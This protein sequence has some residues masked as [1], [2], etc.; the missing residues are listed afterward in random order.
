MPTQREM[1]WPSSTSAL[2]SSSSTTYAYE[3]M[4]GAAE[5]RSLSEVASTAGSV[6]SDWTEAIRLQYSALEDLEAPRAGGEFRA[7]AEEARA[8]GAEVVFGDRSVGLTTRRLRRLVPLTELLWALAFDDSEWA[9]AAAVRRIEEAR[10]LRGGA[11]MGPMSGAR[12]CCNEEWSERV[13]WLRSAKG[14]AAV[15]E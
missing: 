12:R 14:A 6:L 3:K 5:A 15:H 13:G 10:A 8:L 7:A 2:A 1:M 9:E 4:S 11:G